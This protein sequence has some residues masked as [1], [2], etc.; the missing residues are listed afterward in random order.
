M[1]DKDRKLA[2]IIHIFGVCKKKMIELK[3][4]TLLGGQQMVSSEPAF[5]L[6]GP[7]AKIWPFQGLTP[8]T[9]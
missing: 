1:V 8:W 4:Q 5:E 9:L 2:N 6:I 3:F 7:S